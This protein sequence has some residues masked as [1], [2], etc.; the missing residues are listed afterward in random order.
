MAGAAI[1]A[2]PGYELAQTHSDFLEPFEHMGRIVTGWILRDGV[3]LL[4]VMSVYGQTNPTLPEH[5]EQ[6]EAMWMAVNEWVLLHH[7]QPIMIAGDFNAEFGDVVEIDALLAQGQLQRVLEMFTSDRPMTHSAGR[8]IDHI[9]LS[10]NVI[11][12]VVKAETERQWRFP[13]H[14]AIAA[15]LSLQELACRAPPKGGVGLNVPQALPVA[16]AIKNMMQKLDWTTHGEAFNSALTRRDVNSA[17]YWWTERW[18]QAT[19]YCASMQGIE[20]S[21]HMIGR[22]KGEKATNEKPSVSVPVMNSH[23]PVRVRQLRRSWSSMKAW[24]DDSARAQ[25]FLE[26]VQCQRREQNILRRVRLLHD[27]SFDYISAE[28]ISQ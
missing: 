15:T 11:H 27:M 24:L 26:R 25:T 19:L 12:T 2:G 4:H 10:G 6:A 21:P 18:E 8:R 3:P 23:L 7:H 16:K 17:L 1:L 9:L 13:N 20:V 22:A 28:S 14:K 5:A